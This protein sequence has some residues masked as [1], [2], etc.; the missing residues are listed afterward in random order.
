MNYDTKADG[1]Y[2]VLGSS[3][4]YLS[5]IGKRQDHLGDTG[6]LVELSVKTK[7]HY[8]DSPGSKNYHENAEF[9]A[10]FALVVKRHF[11]ELREEAIQLMRDKAEKALLEEEDA[12][13][14]RLERIQQ[15]KEKR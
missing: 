15:L 8:Q 11:L 3:L 12:L 10:A 6:S 14:A 4:N 7:I 2:R 9:D 1:L 5:M 13:K